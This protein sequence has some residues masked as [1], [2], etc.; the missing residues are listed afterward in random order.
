MTEAQ[1]ADPRASPLLVRLRLLAS[2]LADNADDG[3]EHCESVDLREAVA[4]LSEAEKFIDGF[5]AS[6][7]SGFARQKKAL[8]WLRRLNR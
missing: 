4:L 7:E 5:A 6:A 2:A 3:N 1:S 8:E